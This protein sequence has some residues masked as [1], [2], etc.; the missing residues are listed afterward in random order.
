MRR[1]I[2]LGTLLSLLLIIIIFFYYPPNDDFSPINPSWNGLTKFASSV[3]LTPVNDLSDLRKLSN[4][5]NYTIMII[6]PGEKFSSED[7]EAVRDFLERG[8]LLLIADDF[9]TGNQLL[10]GL[11][12]DARF[13][14]SPLVDPLFMYKNRYLPKVFIGGRDGAYLCL[15]YGTAIEGSSLKSLANSSSFS[16]LDLNMNGEHDP[17]EPTG[18]LTVMASVTSGRGKIIIIAD[19]S[20]AINSMLDIGGCSN[21]RFLKEVIGG[22]NALLDVSHLKKSPYTSA[23]E[24]MFYLLN[25][26]EVRYGLLLVLILL[27]LSIIR[28]RREKRDP[29]E[30]ILVRHPDWDPKILNKLKEE[31]EHV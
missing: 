28:E 3:N 14:G 23:R 31:I 7:I 1:E 17:N 26:S 6:G 13:Y 24:E 20:I 18:P 16:F 27:A 21:G 22:R 11:G 30:E 12:V 10:S 2:S 5:E 29:L 19:P 8:G 4:A 9:G 15:N 25:I